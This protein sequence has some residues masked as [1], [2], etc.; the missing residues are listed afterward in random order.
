MT[1]PKDNGNF[2]NDTADGH[3][4]MTTSTLKMTLPNDNM[5]FEFD[6]AD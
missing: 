2:E 3:R 4:R 5:N 1:P 6:T